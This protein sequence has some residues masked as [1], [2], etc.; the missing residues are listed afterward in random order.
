MVVVRAA[1]GESESPNV[2]GT[3]VCRPE[4]RFDGMDALTR[5]VEEMGVPTDRPRERLDAR[6][7]PPPQPLRNTLERLAELDDDVVLVQTNDRAPKHLYP[8]LDDRGYAYETVDAGDFVAT[9]VWRDDA[10][11]A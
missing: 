9:V 2:F 11:T 10:E 1:G 4:A 6:E 8:K 5:L 3:T 7:L